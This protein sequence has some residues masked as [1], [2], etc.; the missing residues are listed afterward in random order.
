VLLPAFSFDQ[1]VS[2]QTAKQDKLEIKLEDGALLADLEGAE[3]FLRMLGA[4]PTNY[5]DN[6][7][8]DP[9][10]PYFTGQQGYEDRFTSQPIRSVAFIAGGQR[11]PRKAV[12]LR[13]AVVHQGEVPTEGQ[14]LEYLKAICGF[15]A[16]LCKRLH[17]NNRKE[18]NKRFFAKARGIP[19]THPTIGNP[20]MAMRTVISHMNYP[21]FFPD[22]PFDGTV[23]EYI[24]ESRKP[25]GQGFRKPVVRA[26]RAVQ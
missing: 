1:T 19:P 3:R 10:G 23:E 21:A 15:V 6:A 5:R 14:A 9:F 25:R 11:L 7:N 4:P 8:I 12:E 24:R 22:A 26:E 16:P 2:P 18:I 20:T 17:Q 13:N